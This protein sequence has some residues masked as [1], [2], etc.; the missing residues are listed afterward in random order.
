MDLQPL[1]EGLK[2]EGI[3]VRELAT[4]GV[5]YHSPLLDPLLPDLRA[6]VPSAMLIFLCSI[7]EPYMTYIRHS[8]HSPR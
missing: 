3:F 5:A 6:G 4:G 8:L 2:G 1:L 7:F